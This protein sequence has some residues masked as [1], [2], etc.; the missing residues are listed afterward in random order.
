M[1]IERGYDFDDVLIVPQYSNINS[2]SEVDVSVDVLGKFK[3]EFPVIASP[4]RGIVNAD[5]CIKLAELGSIGILHRFYDSQFEWQTEAEKIS[6]AKLFGLS[7]GLHDINY[8]DFLKYKPNILLIDIANGHTQSLLDFCKQ[9]KRNID[10]ISP[11]TLLMSGNVATKF[12]ADNLYDA[13]VDLVRCGIGGGG[14]CSTRNVTGIGVPQ[15]TAIGNCSESKAFIVAD[16]GIRNSGDAVKAFAFGG[17]IIMI[18]SLFGQ[19]YESPSQDTIF[20]M[21]CYSDDTQVMTKNGWKFI[22]DITMNDMVVTL[23]QENNAIEYNPPSNLYKYN[24]SGDMISIKSSHVDLMV[25]PNHEIYAAPQARVKDGY[26][27]RFRKIL[28]K[29]IFDY[30]KLNFKCSANWNGKYLDKFLLQNS[31]YVFDMNDWA[32][33]FG[34]WLAE[35]CCRKFYSKKNNLTYSTTISNNNYKLI[36]RTRDFLDKY[37]IKYSVRERKSKINNNMNYEIQTSNKY[38]GGY[39]FQFGKSIDKFIPKNMKELDKKHLEILFEGM[40]DGDGNRT[41]KMFYTSSKQLRDDIS[42]LIIK[43]GFAPQWHLIHK[44]GSSYKK[45][46][47][48]AD[49]YGVS[50]RKYA[51]SI[52]KKRGFKIEK[53]NGNVYCIEVPNNTLFVQ[54]NGRCCWCGNSKKL[55]DMRYTQTKSIEGIEK[56]VAKTMSLQQFVDEFSWGL[57]SACTYLD[58]KSLKEIKTNAEFVLAGSGSIKKLD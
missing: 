49:S 44:K 43:I 20:G 37:E 32:W 9:V 36:N 2:R 28:A 12:G 29:K 3:L 41:R 47:R 30:S 10:K 13:G 14:L 5:F 38:L 58:A 23:N 6:G 51:V 55:Q 39:L 11:D 16:G 7:V 18:G 17:D 52:V 56:S 57:K 31:E 25:T 8:L 22:S 48:N 34:F 15:L 1:Q 27:L 19:T 35:G 4:M 54:R 26:P 53:Y 50:Y 46:F 21:A 33:F 24:Y 42:E 45:F 40:M